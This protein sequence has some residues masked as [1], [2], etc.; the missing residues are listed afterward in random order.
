MGN[1]TE[2][3]FLSCCAPW[4]EMFLL[5]KSFFILCRSLFGK[6]N[7]CYVFLFF[8]IDAYDLVSND[9]KPVIYAKFT[10]SSLN[11]IWIIENVALSLASFV[12]FNAIFFRNKNQCQMRLNNWCLTF[13]FNCNN[14]SIWINEKDFKP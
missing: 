8:F 2:C 1:I 6:R 7:I 9:S 13:T 4:C 10:E 14:K 5:R 12:S 11:L 3:Y